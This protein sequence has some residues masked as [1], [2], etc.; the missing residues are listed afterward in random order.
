MTPSFWDYVF[1]TFLCCL[2]VAVVVVVVVVVCCAVVVVVV[3]VVVVAVVV[4]EEGDPL[5]HPD[6]QQSC[7]VEPSMLHFWTI[8]GVSLLTL[9]LHVPET[10]V[11]CR[12]A[13]PSLTMLRRR[14]GL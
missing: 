14:R 1:L 12:L 8:Y 5:L 4:A 6:K 9:L 11:I 7:S 2:V 3:V 13:P 10:T